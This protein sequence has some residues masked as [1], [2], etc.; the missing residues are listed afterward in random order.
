MT[1]TL[2]TIAAELEAAR[3]DLAHWQRLTTAEERAQALAAAYETARADADAQAVAKEATDL[4]ASFAGLSNIRVTNGS[5]AVAASGDNLLRQLF[6]VTWDG[7]KYDMRSG[8]NYTGAH[9]IGG[10]NR[11]PPNVLRFLI[12]KAPKQIPADIMKLAPGN[13]RRAMNEYFS[14]LHRGYTKGA[15]A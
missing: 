6:V 10:L 14:A 8:Q 7:P 9:R 3:K 1:K 15:E 12:E 5:D 2:S 11:L 13:P 4:E